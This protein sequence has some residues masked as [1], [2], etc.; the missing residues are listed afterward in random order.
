MLTNLACYYFQL[1]YI[2]GFYPFFPHNISLNCGSA[3]L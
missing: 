3:T 2:L 1:T